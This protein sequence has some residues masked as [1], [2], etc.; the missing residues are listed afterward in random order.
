MWE[1]QET[2]VFDCDEHL[3]TEG[4]GEQD[5]RRSLSGHRVVDQA[6]HSRH[7]NSGVMLA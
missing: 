4:G 6:R 5:D 2:I 1:G 7:H 3:D